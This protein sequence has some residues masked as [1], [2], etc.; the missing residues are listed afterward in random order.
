MADQV[1]RLLLWRT[2]VLGVP[3]GLLIAVYYALWNPLPAGHGSR[4]FN[5]LANVGATFG[6]V[7]LIS[8]AYNYIWGAR[9]R[10]G[11][12]WM[13][14]RE[15]TGPGGRPS[16]SAPGC[17]WPGRRDRALLSSFS[18]P[19]LCGVRTGSIGCR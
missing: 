12:A 11:L 14:T 4:F 5:A 17:S 3:N 8:V 6:F 10:R 18:W 1:R 9:F 7:L 16:V 19:Y 2:Q 13:G 15:A